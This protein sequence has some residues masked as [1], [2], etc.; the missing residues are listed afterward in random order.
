MK[1]GILGGTFDPIHNGHIKLAEEAK[2]RLS[3]DEVIFVPAGK[4]WLKAGSYISAA[5]H[6]VKV[7]RLAIETYHCFKL[8]TVEVD[9]AGATYTIDTISELRAQLGEGEELFF[10][11]GWD[12]LARLP[13]WR[14]AAKLI[15]MCHLVAVPRPGYELPDR[16]KLEAAVPGLK[17]NLILLDRPRIDISA[18]EIRQR[19]AQGLSIRRLVPRAVERYI[20]KNRL[21]LNIKEA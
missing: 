9:R 13:H 18:T 16:D 20:R 3:L 21:Y 10:I 7:V 19:V 11:L 6:R 4:P 14:D 15:T 17:Q 1:T 5:E 8:S 12:S 2:V